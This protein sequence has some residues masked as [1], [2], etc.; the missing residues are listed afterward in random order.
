[1]TSLLARLCDLLS[2]P[3]A[4]D[5]T[6]Q[7]EWLADGA[8]RQEEERAMTTHAGPIDWN[9]PEGS[10]VCPTCGYDTNIQDGVHV[11]IDPYNG[12]YCNRCFSRWI[13]ENLPKM[14]PKE[15]ADA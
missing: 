9:L 2:R 11:S 13:A 1:M 4:L 15:P 8:R 6:A 10:H 3:R 14:Q 7:S 12:V 5:L